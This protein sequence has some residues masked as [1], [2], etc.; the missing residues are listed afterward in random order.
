MREK[1]SVESRVFAFVIRSLFFLYKVTIST[2]LG[3][4]CR[5]FPSCSEYAQEAYLAHGFYR[6]TVLTVR[7]VL[8]CHPWCEG[9][10]DCVP[11]TPPQKEDSQV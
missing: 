3:D 9:G 7:R 11:P 8:R 6:G 2:F 4:R 1:K 5:F 10:I